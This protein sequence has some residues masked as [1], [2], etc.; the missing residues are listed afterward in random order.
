MYEVEKSSVINGGTSENE[1]TDNIKNAKFSKSLLHELIQLA[2]PNTYKNFTWSTIEGDKSGTV[3]N[4]IRLS[5]EADAEERQYQLMLQNIGSSGVVSVDFRYEENPFL[6][7]NDETWLGYVSNV[8]RYKHAIYIQPD[9]MM[10][11]MDTLT[12]ELDFYYSDPVSEKLIVHKVAAGLPRVSKYE[13]VYHRVYIKENHFLKCVITYVDLDMTEEVQVNKVQFKYL[14]KYFAALPALA[15]PCRLADI[16]YKLNNHEMTLETYKELNDLR[17]TGPFYIEPCKTSNGALLVKL[18]DVDES[19]FNDIIVGKGLAFSSSF[20]RTMTPSTIN[21]S[22]ENQ[23][24]DQLKFSNSANSKVKSYVC[25]KETDTNPK[26]VNS[27]ENYL[28]ND[29]DLDTSTTETEVEDCSLTSKSTGSSDAKPSLN[30]WEDN[31]RIN[32]HLQDLKVIFEFSS[33]CK[34]S[35]HPFHVTPS[36]L[37]QIVDRQKIKSYFDLGCA[38]GTITAGIGDYLGLSKENI[39]GG[40]V[41][42]EQN[43]QIT[44]VKIN[45]KQS[46]IDLPS[47]RVDLITSFVTFHHIDQLESTL[48]EL[49]RILRPGGYLIVREHDCKNEHALRVKYLNFIHAIMMIAKVGEFANSSSN[50]NTKNE[51]ASHEDYENNTNTWLT[52]KSFIIEY[53]YSI[54][55]LSNM[56]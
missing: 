2:L 14:L 54:N 23:R 5:D 41:Y 15:I 30:K 13:E 36:N 35:S 25:M 33:N 34:S 16:E 29:Y 48:S 6:F 44:H 28:M 56:C 11:C 22:Q 18:Y 7:T 20:P 43:E 50:H 1:I 55:S 31:S 46:T 19:C 3:D 53:T 17:Q 39:F 51:N 47:D 32:R 12:Q 24:K 40:D 52:Q 9:C 10:S 26:A 45:E 38:D 8:D 4:V 37:Q 42:E 27:N 49:V 21:E